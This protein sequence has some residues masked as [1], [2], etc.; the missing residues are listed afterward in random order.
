MSHTPVIYELRHN[1]T[2]KVYIGRSTDMPSRMRK[3]KSL[4]RK[5]THPVRDLQ[6]DY[7]TFGPDISF[8][9]LE[10]VSAGSGSIEERRWM[11]K[12]GSTDRTRGYNYQDPLAKPAKPEQQKPQRGSYPTDLEALRRKIKE[13]GKT[14]DV[15]AEESGMAQSTYIN[16]VSGKTPFRA[17][18]IVRSAKSLGMTMA[19]VDAIF[20]GGS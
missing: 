19:E 4:L 7:D 11:L 14:M 16:R 18:E 17:S 13:S 20:L 8:T 6:H 3:H 1:A 9:V 2:G 12:R 15:L 5:G 10:K